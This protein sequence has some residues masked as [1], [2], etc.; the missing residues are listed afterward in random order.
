MIIG[1]IKL[2]VQLQQYLLLNMQ[3]CLPHAAFV[4][5]RGVARLS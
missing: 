5:R 2:L 3:Y 4:D 1:I